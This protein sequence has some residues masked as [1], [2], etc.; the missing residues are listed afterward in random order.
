MGGHMASTFC[1][2]FLS[3]NRLTQLKINKLTLKDSKAQTKGDLIRKFETYVKK[4]AIVI[5]QAFSKGNCWKSLFV[6]LCE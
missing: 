5:L 2:G 1:S 3:S 6:W 4:K